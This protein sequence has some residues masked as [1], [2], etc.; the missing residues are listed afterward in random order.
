MEAEHIKAMIPNRS[1]LIRVKIADMKKQ[2]DVVSIANR[3]TKPFLKKNN[4]HIAMKKNGLFLLKNNIHLMTLVF[5]GW[6]V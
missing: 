6:A 3:R 4:I 5:V 1:E 2:P